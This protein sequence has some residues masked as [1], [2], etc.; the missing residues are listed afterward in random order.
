MGL[1]AAN[2]WQPCEQANNLDLINNMIEALVK[3]A[4]EEASAKA[5]CDEEL[6]KSNKAK[7]EKMLKLDQF[8]AKEGLNPKSQIT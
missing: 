4:N 2:R 5:F 6:A 7:D 1:I 8:Q 3:E